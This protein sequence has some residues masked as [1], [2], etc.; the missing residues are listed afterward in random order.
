LNALEGTEHKPELISRS[1]GVI[2]QALEI[3]PKK[4]SKVHIDRKRNNDCEYKATTK[5]TNELS[6]QKSV[7]LREWGR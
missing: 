6:T 7:E 1:Q 3:R 5:L 4:E 2:F